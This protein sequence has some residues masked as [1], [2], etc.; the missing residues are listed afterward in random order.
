MSAS[1]LITGFSV[2]M[3]AEEVVIN[4]TEAPSNHNQIVRQPL[5]VESVEHG[6]SVDRDRV[7]LVLVMYPVKYTF[8]RYYD[9]GWLSKAWLTLEKKSMCANTTPEGPPSYDY[10]DGTTPPQCD[11]DPTPCVCPSP[12]PPAPQSTPPYL[13]PGTPATAPPTRYTPPGTPATP[14]PPTRYTPSPPTNP[15]PTTTRYVPPTNPPT[16]T[17][18]RYTPPGTVP[19]TGYFSSPP[20][21]PSTQPTRS[22]PVTTRPG[23]YTSS[24]PGDYMATNA[25]MQ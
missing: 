8:G 4:E 13:P 23:Q 11:P 14:P 3:Y 6:P 5:T 22:V 25:E 12:S 15:P 19:P 17:P 18:T 24:A 10:S 21:P 9:P 16:P 2:A 7:L 20:T 1:R